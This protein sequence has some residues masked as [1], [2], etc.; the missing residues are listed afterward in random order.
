MRRTVLAFVLLAVLV[1]ALLAGC[2]SGPHGYSTPLGPSAHSPT[3]GLPPKGYVPPSI[4][5]TLSAV[6]TAEMFDTVSLSTVPP[7][8]RAVA[9]YLP[10][11][12]WPTY[13][14]LSQ[15]FPGAIRVP[16]AVQAFVVIRGVRMGCLDV[17]PGDAVPSQVPGWIRAEIHVHVIPCIYSN[18]SEW[19]QIDGYLSR[20][21][22]PRTDYLRWLALW[23]YHPGILA[24][25][26]AQQWTQVALHRNLDES[27]VTLR[28]LGLVAPA[29]KPKPAP[30]R[31][32][33]FG[34][35]ATQRA[36]ACQPIIR[37]FDHRDG[38][39]VET[40]YAENRLYNQLQKLGCRKPYRRHAC[41]ELGR[42][43]RVLGQRDRWF[44]A[45]ANSLYREYS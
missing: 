9:G 29:P 32:V 39:A 27:T 28:F 37:L 21:G 2:G 35:H 42:G 6:P 13:A 44:I 10:P 18:L 40:R 8:P 41:V 36:R 43:L 24:G 3:F 38:A 17:E 1:A 34:Q 15:A 16:I 45:H 26:D 22:I 12:S 5:P 19:G 20:A 33:C 14:S 30:R 4:P 7:H 25:F 23:V 11:S 31:L